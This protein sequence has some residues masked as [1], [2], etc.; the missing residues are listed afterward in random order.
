[1]CPFPWVSSLDRLG[2]ALAASPAAR[3][4]RCRTPPP[5]WSSGCSPTSWR[6]APVASG[7][8]PSSD[9]LIWPPWTSS[10]SS[11]KSP[12][13]AA[14]PQPPVRLTVATATHP[15]A[16]WS[17]LRAA[18]N[19]DHSMPVRT[20]RPR[21]RIL[22]SKHGIGERPEG[23]RMRLIDPSLVVAGLDAQAA[24]AAIFRSGGGGGGPSRPP[25]APR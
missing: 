24:A 6:F 19:R 13:L 9:R 4:R 2:C 8:P 20:A 5:T 7:S 11:A 15:T 14:T 18:G 17:R 21:G 10:T 12:P 25:P 23:S 3:G 16:R 22:L 1:A